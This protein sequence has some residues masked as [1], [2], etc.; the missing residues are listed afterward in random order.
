MEKV[1]DMHPFGV[2]MPKETREWLKARAKSN[3]RT[4][5]AEVVFILEKEK[6]LDAST[7]KALNVNTHG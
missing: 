5:N 3:H 1:S 6:A 7:S 4:M 2:R